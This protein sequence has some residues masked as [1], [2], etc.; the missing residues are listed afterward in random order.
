MS[1]IVTRALNSMVVGFPN[2]H[3]IDFIIILSSIYL[4]QRITLN[5]LSQYR[6]Q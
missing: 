5:K 1:N 3:S 6:L 2:N 4:Q